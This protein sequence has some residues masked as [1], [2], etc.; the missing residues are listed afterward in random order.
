[1]LT[2]AE[3]FRVGF[4]ERCAADGLSVA[5]I[6]GRIKQAASWPELLANYGAKGVGALLL[7]PPVLGGLGGYAAGR[8]S[9]DESVD[10]AE[11]KK[12]EML[13]ETRQQTQRLQQESAARALEQS[14]KRSG[15]IFL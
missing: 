10:P 2:A 7:A 5:E 3:A 14:R 1:M 9:G 6:Q 11:I 15:R 13:A 12:R 4:M 8:I